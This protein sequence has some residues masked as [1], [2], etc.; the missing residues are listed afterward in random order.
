[1]PGNG[2]APSEGDRLKVLAETAGIPELEAFEHDSGEL[3]VAQDEL[4]AQL[5]A[6]DDTNELLD[7]PFFED[8][9]PTD[10]LTDED[11]RFDRTLH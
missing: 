10:D 11:L 1:M 9:E 5:D 7:D 6:V 2:S 4:R 3:E 8:E